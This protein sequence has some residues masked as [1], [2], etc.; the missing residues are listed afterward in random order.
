MH[1]R[2]QTH[3]IDVVGDIESN[4]DSSLAA[5]NVSLESTHNEDAVSSISNTTTNLTTHKVDDDFEFTYSSE[6]DFRPIS[7]KAGWVPNQ[8]QRFVV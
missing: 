7:V 4:E 5:T 2:T 3:R 6:S 1:A 8:G